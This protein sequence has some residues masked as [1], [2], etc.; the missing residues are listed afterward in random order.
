MNREE[1]ELKRELRRWKV[2]REA[3]KSS[4]TIKD[5]CEQRKIKEEVE[6]GKK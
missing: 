6:D 5:Y 4:D 1:F 2:R 3:H